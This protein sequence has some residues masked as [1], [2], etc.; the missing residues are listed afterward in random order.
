MS[1]ADVPDPAFD[2]GLLSPATVR[3][4]EA[5]SDDAVA[6]ALVEVEVALVVAWERAGVAPEGT[7]AAVRAAVGI[8]PGA[9]EL[10]L[11]AVGGGN[12]VIPLAKGL[13]AEVS[14]R[15]VEAARWVHRGPTSQD[16]LD[17]A[18][19]LVA[20]RA[21]DAIAPALA[22]AASTAAT[23]ADAHR[24]TLQVGRT[25]TQH[26]TPIVFG[27]VAA[28]WTLGLVDARD[29]I[30]AARADLPVQLGG[31]SGNLAS[32]VEI[33]GAAAAARLPG[34]LAEELGLRAAAPW[35]VRR[36]PITALGDALAT[37]VDA[38][39]V[40]AVDV[41]QLSR[42]EIA[43]LAEG[44]G[45]E[46]S[47]MPQ[48]RN[49]VASVLLRSLAHRAPGLAADLHRSASSSVDQ[50]ADG[51][52][53]AEWP[54]LRELLRVTLG[55]ADLIVRLLDGLRIDAERMT[56]TV[57]RAGPSILSER[58]SIAQ[59]PE[60]AAALLADPAPSDS[61]LL[62]PATYLGLSNRIIDQAVA[63]VRR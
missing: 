45:G 23:L 9:V 36:T 39:G 5:V 52:W 55:A 43:E 22:T 33:G 35:H 2:R 32:F 8:G 41:A 24:R 49:P 1:T 16:V 12:P 60:A 51:A 46:S 13:R 21:L 19:M 7:A 56:Q 48:K 25:L 18:L 61:P 44:E 53:H 15:H 4:E 27:A 17:T 54:V 37:A 59:G 11:S 3:V 57:H 63:A 50:R 29:R 28:Q 6:R 20:A 40:I 30:A 10:A 47:A 58:I 62:D 26:S 31:A 34:L 42:P 38:A 14:T